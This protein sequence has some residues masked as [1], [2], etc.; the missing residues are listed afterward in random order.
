V[1]PRQTAMS[2]LA[3]YGATDDFIDNGTY[4]DAWSPRG[5]VWGAS[6]N[7]SLVVAGTDRAEM[8]RALVQDLRHG[9]EP[10]ETVDCEGCEDGEPIPR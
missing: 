7:H 4:L 6:G 1:T 2:L 8:W 9:V 3:R 10:C 5:T